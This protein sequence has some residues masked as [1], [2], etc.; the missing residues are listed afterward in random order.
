MQFPN[1]AST[2]TKT[3]GYAGDTLVN[4]LPWRKIFSTNDSD[5]VASINKNLM[6]Y[7][8]EDNNLVFYMDTLFNSDTLYNFNLQA[9]D[10]FQFNVWGFC[11]VFITVLNVDSLLINGTYFRRFFFAEPNCP[12]ALTVLSEIWLEGIGSIH[13]PLYPFNPV[14]F[15]SEIPD[16]M[17]V[18][19]FKLNDSIIW[20]N[21][22]YNICYNN[23]ILFVA[24]NNPTENELSVFPNPASEKINF[25]THTSQPSAI[26]LYDI[27]L[28]KILRKEFINSISL[29]IASL[30]KGIYLFEII[31]KNGLINAGKVI[32]E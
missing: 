6:G 25:S 4:G 13:G 17:L 20:S 22:S 23:I 19:C 1:F 31:D 9:G 30:S 21:P 2:T 16:S 15:S 7:V 24:K 28:R 32:K 3:F 12:S 27:A 11:S 10:S 8:R 18:T 14:E 26:I 29:N 5:F